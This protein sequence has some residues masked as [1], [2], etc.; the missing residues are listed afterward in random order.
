MKA[1]SLLLLGCW[2]VVVNTQASVG[3]EKRAVLLV[4]FLTQQGS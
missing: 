1:A 3:R 4:S 2:G